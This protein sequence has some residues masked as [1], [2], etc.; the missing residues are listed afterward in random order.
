MTPRRRPGIKDNLWQL[1]GHLETKTPDHKTRKA[2]EELGRVERE[3]GE[4]RLVASMAANRLVS[5][6]QDHE[7]EIRR[8]RREK[9]AN[10]LL[11]VDRYKDEIRTCNQ[12]VEDL[13]RAKESLTEL[14]E[15]IAMWWKQRRRE[16]HEAEP[17]T[18]DL[19]KLRV[20]FEDISDKIASCEGLLGVRR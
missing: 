4:L 11:L 5:L 17:L 2:R 20:R 12:A 19:E 16:S 8:L 1:I 13:T 6:A 18:Y 3:T 15:E 14:L 10:F 9:P 7:L